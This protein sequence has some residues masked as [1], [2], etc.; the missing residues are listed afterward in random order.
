MKEMFSEGLEKI[1]RKE[2]KGKKKKGGVIVTS[3]AYL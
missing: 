1:I 2:L 3:C